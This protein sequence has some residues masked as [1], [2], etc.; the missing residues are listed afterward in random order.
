MINCGICDDEKEIREQLH[1]IV[2]EFAVMENIQMKIS[3]YESGEELLKEEEELQLLLLDI[4]M[5]GRN[6]LDV[7][8][9]IWKR[10]KN[11]KIIFISNLSGPLQKS[12]AQNK[13]HSFAY[14]EKPVSER[15]L[16]K[17]LKDIFAQK[18]EQE[19]THELYFQGMNNETVTLIAEHIYYFEY[20]PRKIKVIYKK[21]NTLQTCFVRDSINNIAEKMKEYNFRLSHK[22]Y[23][24]NICHV[25][26]VHGY[27]IFMNEL[28]NERIPLSQKRAV[29]FMREWNNTRRRAILGE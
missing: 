12:T 10:D 9:E 13:V 26:Q 5:G 6:G 29:E 17:Q 7:G 1:E 14:L 4:N 8:Q 23:V 24:V 20:I 11:I 3:E 15:E 28:E 21:D 22:A 25:K 27:E 19:K 2:E 16:Y 18:R